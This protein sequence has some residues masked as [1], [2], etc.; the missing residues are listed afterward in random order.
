MRK[1]VVL[2][3]LLVIPAGAARAQITC[4]LFELSAGV[5]GE[6]VHVSVSTD[7]PDATR[8]AVEVNRR[9]WRQGRSGVYTLDYFATEL[10]VGELKSGLKVDVSKG[11]LDKAMEKVNLA[12]EFAG[13]GKVVIKELDGRFKV[14]VMTTMNQPDEAFGEFNRKL[15]GMA[16]IQDAEYRGCRRIRWVNADGKEESSVKTAAKPVLVKARDFEA[17]KLY[18]LRRKVD[19]V[20]HPKADETDPRV[21]APEAAIVYVDRRVEDGDWV[22]YRVAVSRA[23][24]LAPMAFGWARHD[25][26]D[27]KKH[28]ETVAPGFME[29]LEETGFMSEGIEEV[30][31]R[32]TRGVEM[33]VSP[34][35]VAIACQSIEIDDGLDKAEFERQA[36]MAAWEQFDRRAA[37]AAVIKIQ[38]AGDTEPR[39]GEVWILPASIKVPEG[40][41]ALRLSEL[42]RTD[43]R[44]SV[45]IDPSYFRER[46]K[47]LALETRV[48]LKEE[49]S[50]EVILWADPLDIGGKR[51]A[52][53]AGSSLARIKEVRYVDIGDETVL[54]YLV[55]DENGKTGWVANE[56]V[57]PL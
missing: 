11:A 57:T 36:R 42:S 39:A 32:E 14:K 1:I 43:V 19:L 46:P 33:Q 30:R 26:F 15:E 53:I 37:G 51:N 28:R 23:P 31:W 47:A 8:I 49:G 50:F 16:V 9:Y 41:K 18:V 3:C 7:L 52:R 54:R 10:S 56:V 27:V 12:S 44:T 35:D 25:A 4:N 55:E 22:W 20:C 48:I 13:R 5:S 45:R 17:G 38:R 29:K 40:L 6:Q 34:D 21:M 24:D 2:F